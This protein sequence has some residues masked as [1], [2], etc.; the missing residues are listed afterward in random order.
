LHTVPDRAF[1]ATPTHVSLPLALDLFHSLPPPPSP[2][3]PPPPPTTVTPSSPAPPA[4]PAGPRQPL[5]LTA[6]QATQLPPQVVEGI[7]A[8]RLALA[9]EYGEPDR[10][11]E[12][13]Q[14]TRLQAARLPFLESQPGH[15][16]PRLDFVVDGHAVTVDV[17]GG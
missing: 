16:C 14:V 10:P 13:G 11:V 12:R 6:G 17:H 5:P 4:P 3:P 1:V 2:R 8:N 15:P 7:G 9:A